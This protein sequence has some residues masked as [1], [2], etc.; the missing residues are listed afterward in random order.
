[1][2]NGKITIDLTEKFTSF[3]FDLKFF[4]FGGKLPLFFI[5]VEHEIRLASEWEKITDF[6]ATNFQINVETEFETW[7][8]YLF[9]LTQKAIDKE[10]K[11]KIE[12]DTWSSRKIVIE[13][14]KSKEDIIKEHLSNKDLSIKE[15]ETVAEPFQRDNIISKAMGDKILR[16]E[17]T[18]IETAN[19]VLDTIA[20]S[21][22]GES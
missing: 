13:S 3:S 12:N 11:Y 21:I 14:R 2:D 8:I 15:R 19:K 17:R 16:N 5:N 9:F 18:K 1:M 7:N 10:L 22:R 6:I 4:E 20:K